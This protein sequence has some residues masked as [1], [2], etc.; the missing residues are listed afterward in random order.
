MEWSMDN[1]FPGAAQLSD[2]P[3]VYIDEELM[4]EENFEEGISYRTW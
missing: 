1:N 3:K 4:L 2:A